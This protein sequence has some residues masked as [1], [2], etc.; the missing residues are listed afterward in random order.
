MKP[1]QAS[2]INDV[3]HWIK[4]NEKITEGKVLIMNYVQVPVDWNSSVMPYPVYKK[5]IRDHSVISKLRRQEKLLAR[6]KKKVESLQEEVSEIKEEDLSE[7]KN[8]IGD[9]IIIKTP[10]ELKEHESQIIQMKNQLMMMEEANKKMSRKL[11]LYIIERT[12]E[13]SKKAQGKTQHKDM[14]N[15]EKV[16]PTP[17]VVVSL[18]IEVR[19]TDTNQINELNKY[20]EL[21][22]TETKVQ[23]EE[24]KE[25]IKKYYLNEMRLSGLITKTEDL[26]SKEMR[27]FKEIWVYTK[28]HKGRIAAIDALIEHFKVLVTEH[29][30]ARRI[31][32]EQRNKLMLL[33]K[34]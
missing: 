15:I 10:E 3:V 26:I 17:P 4:K 25:V 31:A 8:F 24:I 30:D 33:I 11:D 29:I 23:K 13:E 27:S 19:I 6:T 20:N 32:E 34:R 7:I 2:H 12:M 21:R 28:I 18:P 5:I 16:R 14:E 9:P 22:S 1:N